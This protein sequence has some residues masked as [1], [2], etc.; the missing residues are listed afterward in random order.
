NWDYRYCWLRDASLTVR[1]FLDL[2]YPDEAAAFVSWLLQTTRLTRPELRILYD[3]YGGVPAQEETLDHLAGFQGSRPVRI[4]N[5]ASVQLQLDT[6]GEVIDAVAWMCRGG[7]SLDRETEG[8][9]RD[10][11]RY[12]CE[13]WSRPDQG[14]WEP[15]DEPLPH[16]HSRVLCWTALDR[17]LALHQ[18]GH[19]RSAPIAMYEEE[20]GKIR[21][22]VERRGWNPHL[23]SYTHV[24][25]GDTVDASLLLL[26][27]YGF[28]DAASARMRDTYARIRR[29]LEVRPGLLLRNQAS[30]AIGEG[31]FGVASFWAVEFLAQGG[32]T[33]AEAESS[34]ASLLSTATTLGLFGEEMDRK[35]GEPLGNFPQA[36]THVGLIGAALALE[37]RR[38]AEGASA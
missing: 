28:A 11:G 26:S 5:A 34:F 13:N 16:T 23:A 25:D 36:F 7:A 37:K 14:I 38:Q 21:E 30:E 27:W 24:L 4:R 33:M 3:V 35:T 22:E 32:G 6:Y 9:L 2:G 20:R 29:L 10:F 12:V 8:M 17:L 15:R 18:Q 31:A 1:A 19:L